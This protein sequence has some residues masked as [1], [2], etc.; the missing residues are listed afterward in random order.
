MLANEKTAK[1]RKKTAKHLN[2]YFFN[3]IFVKYTSVFCLEFC[4]LL[5]NSRLPLIYLP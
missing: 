3:L 1:E 4:L 5:T 2:Y